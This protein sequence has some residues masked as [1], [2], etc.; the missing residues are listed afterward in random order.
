MAIEFNCPYCTSLIRVPDNAGGGKGRCPKC[1][2]RLTVPKVSTPKPAAPSQP[3]EPKSARPSVAEPTFA[4]VSSTPFISSP[5]VED[6]GI[7][8]IKAAE[9]AEAVV[10]SDPF[11]AFAESSAPDRGYSTAKLQPRKSG[12]AWKIVAVTALVVCAIAGGVAWQLSLGDRLGG[13]LIA[14]TAESLD[15]PPGLVGKSSIGQSSE[16]IS[17]VLT[18][19]EKSS[20]PLSSSLM[21]VQLS[22][23]PKGILIRLSAGPQAQFY[24]VEVRD[25]AGLK[26]YQAKHTAELEA[27]R[28]R[29]LEQAATSFAAAYY[30]VITKKSDTSTL[31]GFRDTLALPA[32]VRGV[33]H[34]LIAT[35][36]RT[37]YPC[38]YEDYD[39]AW[40]FL[41]PPDV[42]DFQISGRKHANGSVVFPGAYKV[43]VAGEVRSPLKENDA[44]SDNEASAQSKG[45]SKK[46]SPASEE[47][48]E[49]MD[50]KS[51]SGMKTRGE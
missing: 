34:Q 24:K 45:K 8:F 10:S 48:A 14:E 33:G 42:K 28:M 3:V 19:L 18:K 7:N 39:G 27:S 44:K 21:Q 6:V 22:G 12:G 5:E 43:I 47:P 15:L 46:A 4:P 30:Q 37:A 38:V 1:S 13:E 41:M 9:E 16:M 26:L 35:H 29:E 40:Y 2:T 11:D 36:G 25:N 51:D 49:E 31:P 32:L 17:A 20:V 50:S 23:S